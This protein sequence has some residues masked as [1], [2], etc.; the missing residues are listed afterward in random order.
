VKKN[1][2]KKNKGKKWKSKVIEGHRRKKRKNGRRI[3]NRSAVH[4]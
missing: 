3:T 1:G 4:T 2:I